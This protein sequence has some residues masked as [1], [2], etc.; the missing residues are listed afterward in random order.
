[1]RERVRRRGGEREKET[2]VSGERE[3]KREHVMYLVIVHV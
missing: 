3:R 1:M 2:R